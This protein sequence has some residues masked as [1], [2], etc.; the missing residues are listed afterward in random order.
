MAIIPPKSAQY[1]LIQVIVLLKSGIDGPSPS[2][3]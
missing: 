2:N 1:L 3:L